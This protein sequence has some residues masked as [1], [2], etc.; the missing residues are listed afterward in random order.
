MNKLIIK[1]KFQQLGEC[2]NI[3]TSFKTLTVILGREFP[4]TLM[5]Q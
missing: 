4:S 3:E 1:N 5:T 2:I